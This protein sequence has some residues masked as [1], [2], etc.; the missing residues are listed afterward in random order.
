MVGGMEVRWSN[1]A[2]GAL[3]L[4][5]ICSVP[6]LLIWFSKPTGQHLVEHYV[7]FNGSIASLYAGSSV[8]FGGIPIGHVTAVRIDPDDSSLARVDILVDS[9]VSIYADSRATLRPQGISGISIVDISRGGRMR[10]RRLEPG[11]EI[12]ARYSPFRRL[13]LGLP[14]MAANGEV[15]LDRV[16]AF[17]TAQNASMANQILANID[18]LRIQFAAKSPRISSFRAGTNDAIAQLNQAWAEFH[19][20]R[21]NIDRLADAA[22]AINEEIQNLISAFRGTA[23]NLNRFVEEDRR[24]IQDFWS[25]GFSQLSPMIGGLHRLGANLYRLWTE[26]RKDPVRFFL[27][28]R[29]QQ[30]FQPPPSISQHH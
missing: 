25:N 17:F 27:T 15:L 16:R 20:A 10:S 5:L 2:V 9:A 22:N 28:A 11:E 24:P 21:G 12:A 19:Q 4:L 13:L 30:G 7:R 1:I 23:T 3:T 29:E 8:L 14:E 6:A 18:K 26:V